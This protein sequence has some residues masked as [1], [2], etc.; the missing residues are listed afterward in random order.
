MGIELN[1]DILTK[2]FDDLSVGVG[3][4]YVQDTTDLESIH[5]VFMNKVILHE[6]R[7]TRE[8][9]F[10]KRIIEVAPEA[11]AHEGGLLVMETYRKVAAEGGSVN[12][13]VVEYSNTMVAGLYECSVHHIEANYVYVQLRNVTELEKAKIEIEGK[14]ELEK[15]NRELEQ[16]THITSHD[17][18]EPLNTI[19]AFSN[20][21]D[22]E[23]EALS[24]IGQK[25]LAVINESAIRMKGFINALLAYTH[26]G[27]GTHKQEVDILKVI[28]DTKLNLHDFIMTNDAHVQ[29]VG[30]PIKLLGYESDLGI[31]FQNLITNG[32]KYTTKDTLPVIEIDVEEAKD[33]YKFIVSDNG[34]G[35][36]KAYYQKVFEV[37][38]RL[39]SQDEYDGNGIGLSYCKKVVQKHGG[40]IWID[41]TL[42]KGTTFYF[43]L[44]KN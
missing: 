7:K 14:Y 16:F 44:S 26:I 5:Y 18:Q 38:Q 4:F 15:Q 22:N 39:H 29:F 30:K 27:R 1:L 43:T 17:L 12:L 20:L 34:I 40:E 25:S 23:K 13:G 21:I 28:E 42:G 6:M 11:F 33:N 41:S 32:I 19:I 3:I 37:F 36:A 35:I 2:T 10:G 24:D 9:V 31:L 8:E